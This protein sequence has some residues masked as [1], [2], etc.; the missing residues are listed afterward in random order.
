MITMRFPPWLWHLIF[1]LAYLLV[2]SAKDLVYYPVFWANF[3]TNL[4]IT[5]PYLPLVYLNAYR[6]LPRLLLHKRYLGYAAL[7]LGSVIAMAAFSSW[8]HAWLFGEVY[9]VPERA[10][11]FGSLPGATAIATDLLI[12]LAFTSLLVLLRELVRRERYTRELEGQKLEAELGLLKNQLNPHF[13]FNALNSIFVMAKKDGEQARGMILQLSDLLSHQ[14]YQARK[15]HI[16]LAAEIEHLRNYI[17]LERVRHG[18]LATVT[19]ELT[20]DTGG[21][22]IAPMLFLPLAENAFKHGRSN[23]SYRID[24]RLERPAPGQVVFRVSNTRPPAAARPAGQSG[25]VGL[26]NVRRRLELLY[27]D[28]HELLIDAE[29]ALFAVT[30]RLILS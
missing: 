21:L 10:A 15:D 30:L 8:Q 17:A 23:T 16:P 1:W 14:L 7:L 28:R 4:I 18:R 20:T 25:G 24:I 2:W 5:A 11:F 29:E 19:T 3:M 9:G 26:A 12:L 22:H 13:L 27:P 6:W